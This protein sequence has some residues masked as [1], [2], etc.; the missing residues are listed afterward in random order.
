MPLCFGAL[1][2]VRTR[3]NIRSANCAFEVQTFWPFTTKK[4][5]SISAL[6]LRDARSEPEPGS[7]Y[8]CH[9]ISSALRIFGR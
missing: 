9:Q 7:E 6:V 1:E 2:S 4:S 3:Q 8:P 5:P